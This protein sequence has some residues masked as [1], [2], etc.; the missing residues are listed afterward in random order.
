MEN[1]KQKIDEY[2]EQLEG[3]SAKEIL[4]FFDTLLGKDLVLASSLGAEDQ[5]LTQLFTSITNDARVFVLDTGR[6]HQETYDVM[7]KSRRKYSL[8][9]EVYFPLSESVQEMV[10][11]NGP[12]LFYDSIESRKLCCGIRKVEPLGRALKTC[13]AW[14]TGLRREQAVTRKSL[15]I[16]EWDEGH[17]LL[18]INPLATWAEEDVWSYIKENKIP[19]NDLHDKGFPSIGCAPCTRAIEKGED[20][21]AGRW[22][23]ESPELKE[24]GLHVKDGK[25]VRKR[26]S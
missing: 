12:N 8:T 13:K 6:L 3:K 7:D 24:C 10:A 4:S 17:Q 11:M 26:E 25:L 1:Y 2:N 9:Y 15:P 19:Y 14:I 21:R 22:W 23:W 18:K 16:V 5:V 20:V